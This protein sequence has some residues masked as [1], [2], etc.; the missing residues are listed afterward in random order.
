MRPPGRQAPPAVLDSSTSCG[1]PPWRKGCIT[2]HSR[3]ATDRGPQASCDADGGLR[4]L[5]NPFTDRWCRL[6][7]G[8]HATYQEA[9]T[10]TAIAGHWTRSRLSMSCTRL[11]ARR[12][13]G[14]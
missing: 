3:R 9:A 13:L 7:R 11:R 8:F 2:A 4:M 14:C 5:L 1:S 10:V 6:I 12:S